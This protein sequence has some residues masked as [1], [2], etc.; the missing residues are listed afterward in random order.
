MITKYCNYSIFSRLLQTNYKNI[1]SN[2]LIIIEQFL[3]IIKNCY[4]YAFHK[5]NTYINKS[6]IIMN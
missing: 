3:M 2:I 1:N 6:K 5:L 4:A